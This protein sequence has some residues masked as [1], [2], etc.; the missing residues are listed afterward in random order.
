ME[1]CLK[2]SRGRDTVQTMRNRRQY[3]WRGGSRASTQQCSMIGAVL[4]Q[5][6]APVKTQSNVACVVGCT[7]KLSRCIHILTAGRCPERCVQ[8]AAQA[9]LSLDY[10]VNVT[11]HRSCT[12]LKIIS[13]SLVLKVF[14]TVQQVVLPDTNPSPYKSWTLSQKYALARV[15]IHLPLTPGQFAPTKKAFQTDLAVL[16]V[17]PNLSPEPQVYCYQIS[18]MMQPSVE[19]TKQV[20]I[21]EKLES[22]VRDIV[23]LQQ[24]CVLQLSRDGRYEQIAIKCLRLLLGL[25]LM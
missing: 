1:T 4:G 19:K 17:T 5:F 20:G 22:D 10:T 8:G 16:A 6:C 24:D 13:T 23:D 25:P 7:W 21:A 11:E 3:V 14:W 18:A 2:R 12:V 15:V 9:Q